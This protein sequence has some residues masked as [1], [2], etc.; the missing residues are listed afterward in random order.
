MQNT[1]QKQTLTNVEKTFIVEFLANS[2]YSLTQHNVESVLEEEE[3]FARL[4]D[5]QQVLANLQMLYS[6]ATIHSTQFNFTIAQAAQAMLSYE[7]EYRDTVCE[8]FEFACTLELHKNYANTN[9][10]FATLLERLYDNY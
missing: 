5:A 6:T 2:V 8:Q 3:Y 7:T 1:T 9:A 4:V 10:N